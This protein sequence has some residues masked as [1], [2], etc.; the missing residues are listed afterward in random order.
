DGG[1]CIFIADPGCAERLSCIAVRLAA[2][3][4]IDLAIPGLE[5]ANGQRC[6]A[7]K[8]EE[9]NAFSVLNSRNAEAA[10]AN[11]ARAEQGGD[12]EIVETRRQWKREVSTSR[13]IFR[14]APIHRVAGKYGMIAEVLHVV[15]AEPTIAVYPTHPGDADARSEW[16]VQGC[17]FYHLADNLMTGD[18]VRSDWR[19]VTFDDVEISA[20]DATCDDLKQHLSGLRLRP[21]KIFDRNP[22]C[23]STQSG[24]E[25]GCSHRKARMLL[26]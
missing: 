23:R 5:N 24:I 25:N 4:D 9:T 21:R 14:V 20:A 22:L 19:Q 8:T 7:P 2:G 13:R 26:I 16:Q 11:D 15:A 6:R 17:A 1:H 3:D 10:E 12:V 18:D